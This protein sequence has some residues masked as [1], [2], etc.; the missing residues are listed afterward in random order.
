MGQMLYLLVRGGLF[1]QLGTQ[2]IQGGPSMAFMVF[3]GMHTICKEPKLDV[4]RSQSVTPTNINMIPFVNISNFFECKNIY[5][6]TFTIARWDA[7]DDS[8]AF[9]YARG[10][11]FLAY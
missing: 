2:G 7:L 1:G 10:R 6:M 11:Y 9:Q 4:Q 5:I 3:S 8:L